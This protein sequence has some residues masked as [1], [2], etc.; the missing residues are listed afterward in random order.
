MLVNDVIYEAKYAAQRTRRLFSGD[1][2]FMNREDVQRLF[3][4]FELEV[5]DDGRG[6]LEV[7]ANL[8]D[9]E[10]DMLNDRLIDIEDGQLTDFIYGG[11]IDL[12]EAK[13]ADRP[14]DPFKNW[15]FQMHS[16]LEDDLWN[17]EDDIDHWL[18]ILDEYP[19]DTI[20]TLW[21]EV[22]EGEEDRYKNAYEQV[23]KQVLGA[24]YQQFNEGV[25]EKALAGI[26]SLGLAFANQV[27]ASEV[28]VYTN[29]QGIKQVVAT[30]EEVPKGK[31]AYVVD[32]E[33]LDVKKVQTRVRQEWNARPAREVSDETRRQMYRTDI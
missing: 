4:H 32:V 9:R 29:D 13:Y 17:F 18:K 31:I 8:S 16:A 28:Y 6:Y 33:D 26:L 21:D 10:A 23:L 22:P 30:Y 27:D 14:G 3:A 5:V 1:Y 19:S 7:I 2:Q 12:K 20:S 15:T 11:Y 25:R 24:H